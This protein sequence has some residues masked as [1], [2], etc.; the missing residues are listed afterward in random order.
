[1][2]PRNR[3][4]NFAGKT[5]TDEELE[6]SLKHANRTKIEL[7]SSVITNVREVRKDLDS[8]VIRFVPVEC[9]MM[10]FSVARQNTVE[11]L[12]IHGNLVTP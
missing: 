11:A 9:A 4:T 3:V 7:V 1:M 10:A 2:H 6:Q 5:P 12:A 8:I